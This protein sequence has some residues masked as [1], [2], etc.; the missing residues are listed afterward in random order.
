[1]QDHHERDE[2]GLVFSTDKRRLDIGLIHRFLV[3]D[4]YW[5]PGIHR[6]LV[7]LEIEHSLCFGVYEGDRQLAFARVVTDRAG[8]AWLADVFVVAGRRGESIGKRLVGFVLQHP[9]L[10]RVRRFMLATRDAHG[11]YAQHGFEPIAEPERLMQRYDP[12]AMS[13]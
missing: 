4:S 2:D 9:D 11:L 5:V 6:E 12:D 8:F 3:E 10:Q 1:M 7:E 13:R